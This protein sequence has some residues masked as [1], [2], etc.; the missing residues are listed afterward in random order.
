[1]MIIK[2][3]Q[4]GISIAAV[5]GVFFLMGGNVQAQTC[6]QNSDCAA[7]DPTSTAICGADGNCYCCTSFQK[8]RHK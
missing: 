7:C 8:G 2:K 1:M 6:S 5:A 3:V 4:T